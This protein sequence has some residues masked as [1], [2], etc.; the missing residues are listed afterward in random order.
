[1]IAGLTSNSVSLENLSK[2]LLCPGNRQPLSV[3]APVV[4]TLHTL[5]ADIKRPDI[6]LWEFMPHI[7]CRYSERVMVRSEGTRTMAFTG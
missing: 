4:V 7:S 3:S 1:M 6:R 2:L 5:P